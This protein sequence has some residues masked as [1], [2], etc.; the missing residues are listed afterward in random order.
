M[1]K[2]LEYIVNKFPDQ[3]TST[4]DLYCIDEDFRVLCEDYLTSIQTI[5]A[6]RLKVLTD[7][8]VEN[9]YIQVALELE[10]EIL[11]FLQNKKK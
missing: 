11:H 4:I 6:S 8:L 7:R 5:E 9:E 10:K 3:A 2:A 1:E